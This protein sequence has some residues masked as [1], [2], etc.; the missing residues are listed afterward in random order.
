MVPL[1]QLIYDL[2]ISKSELISFKV[3]VNVA[4]QIYGF[5]HSAADLRVITLYQTIIRKV[6]W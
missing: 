4:A 6:N 1:A 5:T 2:H 3:A